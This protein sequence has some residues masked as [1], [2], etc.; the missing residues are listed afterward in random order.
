MA[1]WNSLGPS[2]GKSPG[3]RATCPAPCEKIFRLLCRANQ[4]FESA[5]LTRGEGRCARHQRAVGCGGRE[6]KA[7]DERLA[8]ADGEVVWS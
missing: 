5:R 7:K 8:R 6:A 1:R 3:L 2:T 4:W